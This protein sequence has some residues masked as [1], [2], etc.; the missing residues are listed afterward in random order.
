MRS[1][2]D[3]RANLESKVRKME[4]EL[5]GCELSKESLRREKQTVKSL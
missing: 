5:T 1:L 3:E 2:E 4:A